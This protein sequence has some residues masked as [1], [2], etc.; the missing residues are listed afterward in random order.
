MS[1]HVAVHNS[2]METMRRMHNAPM[3]NHFNSYSNQANKLLRTFAAQM[4]TLKR[5]RQ[6]ASQ[7]VRVDHVHVNEGGQAIVGDVHTG[8]GEKVKSEE[9]PHALGYAP[10]NQMQSQNSERNVVS[11]PSNEKR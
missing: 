5:S 4:E 8:G 2:A 3:L 7:T 6:K 9:Q 11:V 1:H 10:G